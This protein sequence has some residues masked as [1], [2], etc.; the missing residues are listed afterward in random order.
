MTPIRFHGCSWDFV[1]WTKPERFLFQLNHGE[2]LYN[3]NRFVYGAQYLGIMTHFDRRAEHQ[4]Q[5]LRLLTS[6]DGDVRNRRRPGYGDTGGPAGATAGAA[7]TVW[8]GASPSPTADRRRSRSPWR[9][10]VASTLPAPQ[11][12]CTPSASA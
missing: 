9:A 10:R 5:T 11:R 4:S 3:N 12:R 8:V 1:T 2:S 6:R 7:H